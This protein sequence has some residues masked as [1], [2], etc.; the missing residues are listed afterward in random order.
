MAPSLDDHGYTLNAAHAM[1]DTHHWGERS[2][3]AD[4]ALIAAT[5]VGESRP[6]RRPRAW[7]M[8]S[9]GTYVHV[10]RSY[11]VRNSAGVSAGISTRSRCT[12]ASELNAVFASVSVVRSGNAAARAAGL[13]SSAR[14]GETSI[15][16]PRAGGLGSFGGH[17]AVIRRAHVSA[18]YFSRGRIAMS[19]MA[20]GAAK[21]GDVR[22]IDASR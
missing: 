8:R 13:R 14:R 1:Q 21:R 11:L 3:E 2:A 10:S 22:S 15:E 5:S 17:S 4:S 18:S 9:T 16:Q 12:S 19:T 7:G 6:H 20:P